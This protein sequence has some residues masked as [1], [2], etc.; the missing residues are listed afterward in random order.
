MVL[1]TGLIFL[2]AVDLGPLDS[3]REAIRRYASLYGEGLWHLVYQAEARMRRE[4]MERLRRRGA[5]AKA[6]DASHPF[7]AAFPWRWVWSEALLDMRFWKDQLEDPALFVM[8]KTRTPGTFIDGDASISGQNASRRDG[9]DLHH[10]GP[11]APPPRATIQDRD[12]PKRKERKPD[13]RAS[14]S[15]GKYVTS[16]AGVTLCRG[17]NEGTCHG[18]DRQGRCRA[19][20][21]RAHQCWFCLSPHPGSS[22]SLSSAPSSVPLSKYQKK[23]AAKGKGKGKK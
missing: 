11:P 6:R 14:I 10:G 5:E 21:S 7:D 1:R 8:T 16:K 12:P 23:Q 15:D 3:Y 20:S 17:Y 22:C 4:H 2:N 13:D 19:N 18:V 9:G